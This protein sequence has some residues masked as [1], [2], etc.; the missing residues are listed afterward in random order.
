MLDVNG[1]TPNPVDRV[2]NL[3]MWYDQIY[4]DNSGKFPNSYWDAIVPVQETNITVLG[5]DSQFF[6]GERRRRREI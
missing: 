6:L 2:Y 5:D 4:G 3:M 1:T